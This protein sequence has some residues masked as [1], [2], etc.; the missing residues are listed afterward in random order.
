MAPE[1]LLDQP[2][3]RGTVDP[4]DVELDA[5]DAA[6]P[7]PSLLD[8]LQPFVVDPA[9]FQVSWWKSWAA[10]QVVIPAEPGLGQDSMDGATTPAAVRCERVIE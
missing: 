9:G 4:L 2:D 8:E 7:N 1:E 3:T 10:A 6:L 5:R